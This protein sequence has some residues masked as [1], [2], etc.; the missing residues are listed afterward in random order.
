MK[1]KRCFQRLYFN[2]RKER[3][4]KTEIKD[5]GIEGLISTGG[6]EGGK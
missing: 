1:G 5:R 3:E 2:R 6:R 4:R